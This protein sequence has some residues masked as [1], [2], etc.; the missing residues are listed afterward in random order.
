[1]AELLGDEQHE[2]FAPGEHVTLSM[3]PDPISEERSLYFLGTR[4]GTAGN[5]IP[6]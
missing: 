3:H 5:E 2:I 6:F 4:E 1:M